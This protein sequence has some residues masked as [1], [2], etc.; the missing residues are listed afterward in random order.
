M[1]RGKVK[2]LENKGNFFISNQHC[3]CDKVLEAGGGGGYNE[4]IYKVE[5]SCMVGCKGGYLKAKQSHNVL[6]LLLVHVLPKI[7]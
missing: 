7:L 4:C 5:I 3:H 6:F 1:V 2:C